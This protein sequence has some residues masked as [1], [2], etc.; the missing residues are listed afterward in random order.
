MKAN[1]SL[2]SELGPALRDL[3]QVTLLQLVVP[4]IVARV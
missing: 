1:F 3:L 2:Q 4:A